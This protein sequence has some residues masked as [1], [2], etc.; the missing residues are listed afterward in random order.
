MRIEDLTVEDFII[1]NK[2]IEQQIVLDSNIEMK[3]YSTYEEVME[4]L[5]LLRIVGHCNN[6]NRNDDKFP[7][8]KSTRSI[9]S[10][11]ISSSSNV[12]YMG[13]SGPAN[14]IL[15]GVKIA[16]AFHEH[17]MFDRLNQESDVRISK[18]LDPYEALCCKFFEKEFTNPPRWGQPH[19]G[20]FN[21]F[22]QFSGFT[23]KMESD[24]KAIERDNKIDEILGIDEIV[25]PETFLDKIKKILSR[26]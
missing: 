6:Q 7:V 4:N 24:I 13:R 3:F 22:Y 2:I 23:G 16:E 26:W 11:I 5:D 8:F 17:N 20:L 1:E 19:I 9:I 15:I 25:K 14:L 10:R 21:P 12:A 18:E